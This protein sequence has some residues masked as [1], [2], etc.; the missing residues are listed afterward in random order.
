M[1]RHRLAGVRGL[2]AQKA[3]RPPIRGTSAL[4]RPAGSPGLPGG[5]ASGD[6]GG[7]LPPELASAVRR[8][9]HLR[10]RASNAPSHDLLFDIVN[11]ASKHHNLRFD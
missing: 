1:Q 8:I 11:Y 9:A 4:R 3:G 5:L 6:A 2:R 10:A 7:M